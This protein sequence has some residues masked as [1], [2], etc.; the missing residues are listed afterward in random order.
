MVEAIK[1][2]YRPKIETEVIS[3]AAAGHNPA[4]QQ[5]CVIVVPVNFADLRG[6]APA[7]GLSMDD[8]SLG[9]TK[10][11]DEDLPQILGVFGGIPHAIS[12]HAVARSGPGEAFRNHHAPANQL[13]ADGVI[14]CSA[15]VGTPVRVH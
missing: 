2:V 13:G 12:R 8:G 5:C 15:Q 4:G 9:L 11:V 3:A 14:R 6:A 10:S 7:P 1:L